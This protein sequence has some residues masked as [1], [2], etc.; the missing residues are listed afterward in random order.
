ME[1]KAIYVAIDGKEFE[2]SNAC[3][4]YEDRLRAARRKTGMPFKGTRYLY[5]REMNAAGDDHSTHLW[6]SEV[7]WDDDDFDFFLWE[8][9]LVCPLPQ[10]CTDKQNETARKEITQRYMAFLKTYKN[11]Y[12]EPVRIEE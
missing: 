10:N 3:K 4:K 8:C 5:P 12:P 7:P 6:V 2:S 11:M 9:G 1:M